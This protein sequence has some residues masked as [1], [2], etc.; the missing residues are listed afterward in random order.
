MR[1]LVR[2]KVRSQSWAPIV[3]D[4]SVSISAWYIVSAATLTRSSASPALC[5]SR[6]PSRAAWS[7]AI[8]CRVPSREPLARSHCPSHDGRLRHEGHAEHVEPELHHLMGHATGWGYA[9]VRWSRTPARGWPQPGRGAGG[10]Q[11]PGAMP[12]AHAGI[13]PPVEWLWRKTVMR[14]RPGARSRSTRCGCGPRRRGSC[15]Q[16]RRRCLLGVRRDRLQTRVS[17]ARLDSCVAD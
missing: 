10:Q 15:S 14:R 4:S 12:S 6:T 3:A 2:D 9:P 16:M 11:R 7:K 1:W 17:A 8:V 13:G 5:A